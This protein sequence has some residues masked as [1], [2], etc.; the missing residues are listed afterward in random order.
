ML[1][2]KNNKVKLNSIWKS[3]SMEDFEVVELKKINNISWVF[4]KSKKTQKEYSCFEEAFVAR[5]LEYNN[6]K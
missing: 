5:F 3:S 1:K 2:N 4:Y 6:Y